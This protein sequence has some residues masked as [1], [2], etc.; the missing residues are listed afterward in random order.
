[1]HS[2]GRRIRHQSARLVQRGCAL[3][4]FIKT[5]ACLQQQPGSPGF[6]LRVF[7]PGRESRSVRPCLLVQTERLAPIAEYAG[8]ERSTFPGRSRRVFRPFPFRG[9][10]AEQSAA[11]GLCLKQCHMG[12]VIIKIGNVHIVMFVQ[13]FH[14]TGRQ[15]ERTGRHA[16]GRPMDRSRTAMS[17]ASVSH[18]A[19]IARHVKD[20]MLNDAQRLYQ[21]MLADDPLPALRANHGL[22][23]QQRRIGPFGIGPLEQ[24]I[25]IL[26]PGSVRTFRHSLQ[27]GFKQD[28]RRVFL[29][30]DMAQTIGQSPSHLQHV[31][32]RIQAQPA[33]ALKAFGLE[34]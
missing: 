26:Q 16:P 28:G 3:Q 33:H 14:Q 17:H 7:Q 32:S 9:M 20:I 13:G 18:A 31:H 12:H 1:M 23:E 10:T 27:C 6:R 8:L 15:H 30:R 19:G 22:L 11:F 2:H 21:L 24:H 25:H 4:S 34:Q 5:L 29:P